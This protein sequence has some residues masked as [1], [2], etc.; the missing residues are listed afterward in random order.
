VNQLAAR[1]TTHCLTGC[2]IGRRLPGQPLAHRPR[3]GPRGDP[4]RSL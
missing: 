4:Q 1:A 3:P 2:A